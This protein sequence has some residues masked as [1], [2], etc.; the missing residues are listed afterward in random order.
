MWAQYLDMGCVVLA[1][2]WAVWTMAQTLGLFHK[3]KAR[4]CA[5]CPVRPVS[6]AR[7]APKPSAI[8]QAGWAKK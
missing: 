1:V 8:A 5:N 6:P 4:A 2:A 7:S 3:T